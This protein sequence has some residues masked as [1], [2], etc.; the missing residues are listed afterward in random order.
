VKSRQQQK[1]G[2]EQMLDKTTKKKHSEKTKKY[3]LT[4]LE[5]FLV[6]SNVKKTQKIVHPKSNFKNEIILYMDTRK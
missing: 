3:T 4:R 6:A 2:E 1:Q 5:N